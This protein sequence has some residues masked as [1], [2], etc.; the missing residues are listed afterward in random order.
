MIAARVSAAMYVTTPYKL[1]ECLAILK[2]QL[3][4]LC[5]T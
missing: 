5:L 4:R 2:T 1:I 3:I